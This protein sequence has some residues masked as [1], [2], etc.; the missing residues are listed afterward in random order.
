MEL[1]LL[2]IYALCAWLV[3]FKFKW[4]PW[5][6]VSQVIT[7]SLPIFGLTALILVLN[8]VAPSSADVRV[9]NYV[10]PINPQVRGLV[11]EVPITPNR[12]IKKGDLLFRIDPTPYEIAVQNAEAR[13][14]QL[15]VQLVTA[16]AT[17]SNLEQQ[18]DSAIGQ[19]EATVARLELSRQRAAQFKE[20]A[21]TGAGNRFDYEQAL[22]DVSNLEGQ[23]QSARAAEQQAREKLGAKSPAGEQDEIANVRAQ[24]L[25][26]EAALA[27]ARWELSQTSYYAPANGTVVALT[28]RP[29][30]IAVPLPMVPA[31][32]F[33]EDEQ[34]I[35]A[36]YNQNEV[37]KIA[38]GQ[39]AEI[40][41]RQYPGRVVKARV[42]SVMWATAQGQLPIG[43][44]RTA[45]GVAPVPPQSLAVR[46]LL[47]GKDEG[48]F[49]AAG[50]QG[51]GA[52]YTDSGEA[53]HILRKI[54]LRISAKLDWLIL[55]LH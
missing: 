26:A 13:L 4:L 40:A 10:V 22:T 50:A 16:R 9:V 51:G 29:G 19:R 28:L 42:D 37:R 54:I 47:D 6:I 23:L 52:V 12:P 39:E 3:F 38:P 24:I 35:L 48:L 41:F 25:Q 32:N 43:D 18:L 1:I 36:I 14:A 34:W 46:L 20:L 2:G 21:A 44:V 11:T 49:L 53:I 5:N 27:N 17:S 15:K 8:V 30:A 45:G 31:M 33:I 7:I 55:K